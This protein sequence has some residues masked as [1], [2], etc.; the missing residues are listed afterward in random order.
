MTTVQYFDL[1]KAREA[2]RISQ[3]EMAV[4]LGISQSQVSRY[5]QDQ[6][7]APFGMVVAWMQLCGEISAK[8][9]TEFGAPYR[10]VENQIRLMSDYA[11]TAPLR[12]TPRCSRPRRLRPDSCGRFATWRVSRG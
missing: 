7:N 6:T 2:A 12:L 11:E 1:T 4:H 8:Q 3:Q 10:D 5:D 9:G